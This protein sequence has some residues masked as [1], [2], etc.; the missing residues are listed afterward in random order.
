MRHVHALL[1]TMLRE[2]VE[3]GLL[4][5]NPCRKT[6]LPRAPRYDAVHL[7]SAQQQ[8]LLDAVNPFYRCLLLTAAS[9]GMR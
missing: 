7:S 5:V 2:A 8:T 1:S 4:L 9:T 6:R 3:E